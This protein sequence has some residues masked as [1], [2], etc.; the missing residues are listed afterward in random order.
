LLSNG[1]TCY[2]YNEECVPKHEII[3]REGNADLS[4]SFGNSSAS[5]AMEKRRVYRPNAL[6]V[7]VN[8]PKIDSIAGAELDVSDTKLFFCVPGK[9]RLDLELPYEVF[10]DEGKVG[11]Y[12]L[13][14]VVTRSLKAPGFIQPLILSCD[15]LVSQ[16]L[17]FQIQLVPLQQG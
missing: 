7:R 17:P 9:Y 2:R 8:T 1:S 6:V 16:N 11:L 3:H 14:P 15:F 10:G 13:N 12:K 5:T 4:K